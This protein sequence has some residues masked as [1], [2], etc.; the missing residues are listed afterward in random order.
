MAKFPQTRTERFAGTM[1][2]PGRLTCPRPE[3]GRPLADLDLEHQ[4]ARPALSAAASK[5]AL[6]SPDDYNRRRQLL[7]RCTI[8]LPLQPTQRDLQG[9]DSGCPSHRH[10]PGESSLG[11]REAGRGILFATP[12]TRLEPRFHCALTSFEPH[13]RGLKQDGLLHAIC[14]GD[15]DGDGRR[16]RDW[17]FRMREKIVDSKSRAG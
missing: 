2:L 14:F 16:M 1:P 11:G 17:L 12:E 8:L 7:M 9:P 15:C 3:K 6:I 5:W 4:N 13:N 10:R